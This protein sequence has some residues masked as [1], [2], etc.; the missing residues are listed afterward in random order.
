MASS[1]IRISANLLKAA[2][3]QNAN[4]AATI[5]PEVIRKNGKEITSFECSSKFTFLSVL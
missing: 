4:Q 5:L 3:A 2:T 1:A